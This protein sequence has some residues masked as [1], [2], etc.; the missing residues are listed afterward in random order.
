MEASQVAVVKDF[1]KEGKPLLAC[2]GPLVDVRSRTASDALENLLGEL[3]IKVSKQTVVYD[4]QAEEASEKRQPVR[5]G[6]AAC[7][8][9]G[10]GNAARQAAAAVGEGVGGEGRQP[11]ETQSGAGAAGP[12]GLDLRL[13][14]PRPIYYEGDDGQAGRRNPLAG[15]GA[16]AA[17]RGKPRGLTSPRNS[18][19][20]ASPAGTRMIRCGTSRTSRNPSRT[21]RRE[22]P[23]TSAAA[24]LFHRR[25]GGGEAAARLVC[26]PGRH[27]EEGTRGGDRPRWALLIRSCRRNGRNCCWTPATGCWAATTC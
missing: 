7:S 26:R 5:D 14:Y 3:H 4:A 6:A 24:D 12:G 2:L 8:G 25:G 16:G 23:T 10:P 27:G 17:G 22:A 11:A 19:G 15:A 9:A 13:R 20:R 1:L 18:C 21:T